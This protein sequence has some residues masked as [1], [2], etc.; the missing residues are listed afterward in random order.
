MGAKITNNSWGGSAYSQA[1]YDA[2]KFANDS[3]SIFVAAAGNFNSNNDKSPFYPS[4]YNLQNVISVAATDHNDQRAFFSN[5]GT[6]VD[7]AAPG[8]NIYSTI[9]NYRK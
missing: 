2:I 5:Y 1:L 8:V 4:S 6:S 3:G 7:I 9:P